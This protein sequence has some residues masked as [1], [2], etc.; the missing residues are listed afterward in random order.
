MLLATDNYGYNV[1]DRAAAE[2]LWS[3]AKE[4]KFNT[5]LLVVTTTD[6]DTTFHMEVELSQAQLLE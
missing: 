3:W 5:E 6:R 1:C 4:L 2:D